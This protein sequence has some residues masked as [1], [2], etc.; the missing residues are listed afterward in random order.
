[1]LP[2]WI[3][4][5]ALSNLRLGSAAVDLLLQRRGDEVAVHVDRCDGEI[6]VVLTN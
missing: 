5:L 1:M 4:T 2:A 6:E 3:D